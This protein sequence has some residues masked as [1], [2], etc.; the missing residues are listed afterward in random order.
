[1]K[2]IEIYIFEDKTNPLENCLSGDRLKR[3]EEASRKSTKRKLVVGSHFVYGILKMKGLSEQISSQSFFTSVH[4]FRNLPFFISLSHSGNYYV[5]GISPSHIGVDAETYIDRDEE[6][7][8]RFVSKNKYLRLE[9]KKKAFYE[10]W[11]KVEAMIKCS[12]YFPLDVHYTQVYDLMI[13]VCSK[14]IENT[15]YYLV[16][17]KDGNFIFV[18][19]ESFYE[20]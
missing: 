20:M 2:E 4:K 17:I 15:V 13:G 1:M 19:R 5:L 10:K 8:D 18:K 9:D 3:F 7:Y 16:N 11:L 12:D 14:K 6:I